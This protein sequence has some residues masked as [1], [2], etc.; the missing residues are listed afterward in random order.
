MSITPKNAD[1]L[2]MT[3]SEFKRTEFMEKPRRKKKPKVYKK[4]PHGLWMR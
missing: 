4:M 3:S 2:R 1:P